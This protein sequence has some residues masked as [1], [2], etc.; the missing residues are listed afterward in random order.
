[1]PYLQEFCN[2]DRYLFMHLRERINFAALHI[3]RETCI[4]KCKKFITGFVTNTD[5]NADYVATKV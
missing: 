4:C 2:F 5:L 1:M 3:P